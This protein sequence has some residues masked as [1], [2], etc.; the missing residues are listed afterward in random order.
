VC[1]K[2]VLDFAAKHGL[3][4]AEHSWRKEIAGIVDA[5]VLYV[6]LELPADK[7]PSPTK[8]SPKK[9]NLD[10]LGALEWF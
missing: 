4:P 7:K 2:D 5:G 6:P 9:H 10:F 3:D 8:S 1:D